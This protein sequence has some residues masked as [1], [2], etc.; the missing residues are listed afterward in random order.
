MKESISHNF[1]RIILFLGREIAP[2]SLHRRT[3]FVNRKLVIQPFRAS[4]R[5]AGR[6][7][8]KHSSEIAT[9]GQR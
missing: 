1:P 2:L 6:G 3:D 8:A 5:K 7:S 9:H 4:A